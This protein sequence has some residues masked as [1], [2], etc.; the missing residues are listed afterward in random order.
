MLLALVTGNLWATCKEENFK[1]E[2]LM[3]VQP[4]DLDGKADGP[5]LVAVDR[6]G[7]GVGELV[8]VLQEGGSARM[9]ME[10]DKA[11]VEAIIVGIVDRV[12]LARR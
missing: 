6:V 10:K 3:I 7:A 11:P 1:G 4:V 12:D 8:L 5:E 2:K 9:I